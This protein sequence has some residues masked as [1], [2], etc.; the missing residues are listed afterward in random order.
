M[1]ELVTKKSPS[2]QLSTA[3]QRGVLIVESRFNLTNSQG[4]NMLDGEH[5]LVRPLS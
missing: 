3:V 2:S 4:L 5:I 1:S